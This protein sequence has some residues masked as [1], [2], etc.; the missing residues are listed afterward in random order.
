[1]SQLRTQLIKKFPCQ[2]RLR[3]HF[4][5]QRYGVSLS[6]ITR[7]PMA[8]VLRSTDKTVNLKTDASIMPPTDNSA[9]IP[10]S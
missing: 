2:K 8:Q 9:Q 10:L 1:M 5:R 4:R 6:F 7:D 3:H